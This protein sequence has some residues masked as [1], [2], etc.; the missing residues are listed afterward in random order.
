MKSL[1][2]VR[3][4]FGCVTQAV[5]YSQVS[6]VP[7]RPTSLSIEAMSNNGCVTQPT[8]CA[9]PRGPIDE[10]LSIK[11]G[12]VSRLQASE[13]LES[14]SCRF[15]TER[16]H[17]ERRLLPRLLLPTYTGTPGENED[18]KIG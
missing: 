6:D 5:L 11:G 2:S 13:S 1:V 18:G 17:A 10:I 16:R 7:S 8:H 12:R 14:P 15:N 4:T 9:S 3:V